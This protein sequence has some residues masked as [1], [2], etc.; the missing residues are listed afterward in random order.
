M[1]KKIGLAVCFIAL[2]SVSTYAASSENI[3][4]AGFRNTGS[5]SDDN[6][7]IVLTKS[8][9]NLLA[10]LQDVKVVAYAALEQTTLIKNFWQSDTFNMDV[11]EDA[12]LRFGVN[13]VV[14]G[15]YKVNM[16]AETITITYS[17]YD[18]P[19]DRIMM[20]RTLEGRAGLDIFDT[21]DALAKKA[22]VAI[23]GSDLDYDALISTYP[24]RGENFPIVMRN[25]VVPSGIALTL[26]AGLLMNYFFNQTLEVYD[27][28]YDS[29]RNSTVSA[30]RQIYYTEMTNSVSLM[31]TYSSMQIGFYAASGVL[32]GLELYLI[33]R[34]PAVSQN[35]RVIALPSYIGFQYQF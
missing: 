21:I 16:E 13:K 22:A 32:A 34:K 19:N 17:V 31:G 8:L 2:L 10:A 24:R 30:D 7:N 18:V 4:V 14:Y 3:L 9:I 12:G 29:Y 25:Y 20:T 5:E 26:G 27:T 33:L 6:I 1:K 35:F 11:I 15:E 28:S 23:I